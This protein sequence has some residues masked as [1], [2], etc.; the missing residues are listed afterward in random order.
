[1]SPLTGRHRL[2]QLLQV[3]RTRPSDRRL[4]ELLPVVPE[5]GE[6]QRRENLLGEQKR[7]KQ[8]RQQQ[9]ITICSYTELARVF[10]KSTLCGF[11]SA[12]VTYCKPKSRFFQV[13]IFTR[14]SGGDLTII[15]HSHYFTRAH[16]LPVLTWAL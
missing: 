15:G 13:K 9:L 12:V 2:R 1:M 5:A 16:D 10:I 14:I 11:S 4:R 3:G 7:Q 8:R 6:L